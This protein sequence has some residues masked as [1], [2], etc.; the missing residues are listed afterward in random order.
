MAREA[1]SRALTDVPTGKSA[2]AGL[3]LS[4]RY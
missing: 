2:N 3:L 1:V 4:T